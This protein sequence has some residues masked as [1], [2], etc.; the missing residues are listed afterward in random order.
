MFSSF[1]NIVIGMDRIKALNNSVQSFELALRQ[2][3]EGFKAGL[4][5]VVSV[6]DAT[7]NLYNA[8]RQ[9]ARRDTTSCW[10]G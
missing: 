4:N 9:Q 2:K 10:T 6:L 3:E 5:D 7:R 8:K 1:Q